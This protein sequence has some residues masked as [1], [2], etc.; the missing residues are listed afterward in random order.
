LDNPGLDNSGWIL[1]VLRCG[2]FSQLLKIEVTRVREHADPTLN[3]L[4]V[5]AVQGPHHPHQ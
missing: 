1:G 5:A 2:K 3:F 4:L